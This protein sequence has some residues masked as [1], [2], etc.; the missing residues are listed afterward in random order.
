[1]EAFLLLFGLPVVLG[2]ILGLMRGV[3][4]YSS[5][6]LAMVVWLLAIGGVITWDQIT[7]KQIGASPSYLSPIV[8]FFW[9]PVSL[10]V[11]GNT[12]SH[13]SSQDQKKT[14]RGDNH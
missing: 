11:W 4:V 14:G 3:K 5:L 10:L 2:F 1:M 9:I 7:H 13:F 6:S 8:V 12:L